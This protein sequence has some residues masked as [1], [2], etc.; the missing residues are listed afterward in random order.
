VRDVPLSS[1]SRSA[2]TPRARRL[3]EAYLDAVD[4]ISISVAL[5]GLI[6]FYALVKERLAG[7]KPLAKFLCV[8]LSLAPRAR[9]P[10]ELA[11]PRGTH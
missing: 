3:A 4:F 7:R 6:V 1:L 8:A 2:L 10:L 5:Y 11:L 9:R